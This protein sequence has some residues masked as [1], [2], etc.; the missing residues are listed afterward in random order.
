VEKRPQRALDTL[1][2]LLEAG[3]KARLIV[4]GDGPL[5]RRLQV[6]AAGLPATFIGFVS[7][8][9]TLA[10]LLAT[11]DIVLAPGPI[12]TFGLAALESLA[13]GT[14][15][16]VSASSALP[17][18]VGSAGVSVIGENFEPGVRELL[19]MPEA[20]RRL[21]ARRRAEEFSWDAAVHGFLDVHES[22]T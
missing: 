9:N 12:E 2:A 8:R 21:A 13:S 4:A 5:R 14:P 7:D 17:A 22:L 19:A 15:V 20:K 6:R 11:A 18:V 10:E 16:V 3:I 1:T